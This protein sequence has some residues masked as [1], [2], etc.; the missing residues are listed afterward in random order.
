[1]VGPPPPKGLGMN[2]V[3]RG[4]TC[5]EHTHQ[6]SISIT[7][8]TSPRIPLLTTVRVDPAV[9]YVALID[10]GP[11]GMLPEVS[12]TDANAVG[13]MAGP[14]PETLGSLLIPYPVDVAYSV[15]MVAAG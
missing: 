10:G 13:G 7:K 5:R 15:D 1:M 12:G 3:A 11:F 8:T 9:T 2:P 14:C 6:A 4:T